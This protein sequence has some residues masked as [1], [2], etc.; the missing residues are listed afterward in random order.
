M[1]QMIAQFNQANIQILKKLGVEVHIAANFTSQHNTMT[2]EK[3]AEFCDDMR[4]QGV[5]VHQIDFERGT[6]TLYSNVK[7]WKQLKQLC[8]VNK[9]DLIHCQS[10]I[11]GV[12]GRMIGRKYAAKVM[13]T[14]HGFHFFKGSPLRNWVIYYPIECFLSDRKSVV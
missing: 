10:P 1:G 7:V 5:R 11:G 9:F 2:P 14:A 12:F 3:L 13:Y 6:G 8:Q 4:A